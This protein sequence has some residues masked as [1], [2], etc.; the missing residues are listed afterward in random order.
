MMAQVDFN[1]ARRELRAAKMRVAQLQNIADG[2]HGDDGISLRQ[3]L[4]AARSELEQA[5]N[6]LLDLLGAW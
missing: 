5:D 6:I 4:T 2:V 3:R 1:Q